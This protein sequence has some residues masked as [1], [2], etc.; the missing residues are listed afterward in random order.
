MTADDETVARNLALMKRADDDFNARDYARFLD[1][2]HH[3]EV[4]VHQTGLPA[5]TH[6]LAAHRREIEALIRAF[7]DVHVH[8][9]PY[10]V[11]FGQGGWTT[12]VGRLTGTFTGE[13]IG[14][15]GTAIGPT[16][17]AFDVTFTTIARWHEERIVEERV[18]WDGAALARQIG[19]TG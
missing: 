2:R 18:L 15:D 9:D 7:P 6:T 17:R 8:N 3:P 10:D 1:E 14:P 19:I 16:G 13:L 11:A 12:A 5:P 4:V